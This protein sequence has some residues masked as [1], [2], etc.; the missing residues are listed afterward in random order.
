MEYGDIRRERFF[1]LGHTSFLTRNEN[2]IEKYE[3][4]GYL[5]RT[6]RATDS[7]RVGRVRSFARHGH[8]W[9]SIPLCGRHASENDNRIEFVHAGYTL[10]PPNPTGRSRAIFHTDNHRVYPDDVT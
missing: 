6:T 7:I 5:N 8:L 9:S 2:V 4:P 3:F 10:V 1:L